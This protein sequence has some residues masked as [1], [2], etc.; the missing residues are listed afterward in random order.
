MI[1]LLSFSC[2]A[3]TRL[4]EDNALTS[5]EADILSDMA[6]VLNSTN[7]FL[8]FSDPKKM[9]YYLAD[10][11]SGSSLE[12]EYSFN[13]LPNNSIKENYALTLETETASWTLPFD[14]LFLGIP[15]SEDAVFHYA[16]PLDENFN[17]KF[18]IVLKENGDAQFSEEPMPVMQVRSVRITDQWF[19]FIHD[20]DD[21]FITPYVSR[22]G[23]G[24][25][26]VEVTN[27][28]RPFELTALLGQRAAVEAERRRFTAVTGIERIYVPS[29]L[30]SPNVPAA[31]SGDRVTFIKLTPSDV[32]AFPVPIK[33][34]PGL[35][36]DWPLS[37]WR[38]K[39]WEIFRWEQF[40][41]ILIIDTADFDVQNKLLKRLAFFAEKTDFRGALWHDHE[42]AGLHGWNAHD[43]RAQALAEF[44]DLAEK[45]NFPLNEEELLLKNIL[46]TEG[47]ILQSDNDIT[48][49]DGGIIS[50]SRQSGAAQRRI[51]MTHEGFHGIFYADEDFR[52]YCQFRWEQ[53][54]PQARLVL[55]AYL[56]INRYDTSWEYLVIKEF[57]SYVLQIPVAEANY[58]FGNTLPGGLEYT[59]YANA[60]PPKDITSNSWPELAAAFYNEAQILSSYADR[61]WGLA[62]GRI[63]TVTVTSF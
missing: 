18:N 10:V 20:N 25:F 61:R 63:W 31:F 26:I 55:K 56:D 51:L 19:G 52:N 60:L 35:V 4:K 12:I 44:F 11:P 27:A 59:R 40:P 21:Y 13:V 30:I 45:T 9:E 1:I 48:A 7:S 17:G 2:Q 37:K 47:I 42:T 16:V 58:Y 36:L 24:S 5:G 39:N 54:D 8:E 15:V 23:G 14:L 22:Q 41:S 29:S 53:I 62:A 32:P 50:V 6:S 57:S 38:N 34:D 3:Q 33:A 43:Y 28:Q 46:L 49:G